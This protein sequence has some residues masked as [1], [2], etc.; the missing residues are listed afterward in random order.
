[1]RPVWLTLYNVF[2][3]PAL[4][5]IFRIYAVFSNKAKQGLEGRRDLFK[6]LNKSLPFFNNGKRTVIIH[7]SSLG[8][9]QQAMP[10]IDEL[11]KKDYN[12][13][14]SFFSPSGYNHSKLQH[15]DIIKIYLPLDTYPGMKKLLGIIKPDVIIFMRY[16]LWYNMLYI[17]KKKGMLTILANGR[18]DEKDWSWK[19]PVLSSM[20][21]DL[22]DMI[23]K[24]FVIDDEDYKNYS[25]IL[26][27]NVIK[28]GD[29]KFERVLQ[30]AQ[31]I[32]Q[33]I[34][35]DNLFSPRVIKDKKVFVIGSSWKEDEELTLPVIN[36][37]LEYEAGLLTFLVPHEPKEKKIA[38]I[39]RNIKDEYPNIKAIRFSGLNN[40]NGENFIIVDRVG[41]LMSL[42]SLAYASYVGGGFRSGLHNI[43]EPAVFNM[44]IFFSNLVKNSD[45][46]EKLIESGCGIVVKTRAQFYREFRKV[47]KE[48]NYRDEIGRK[49]KVVFESMSGTAKRIV[50]SL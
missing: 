20:K 29:S 11:V 22:Y 24:V 23:D 16:D 42:Y 15:K 28:V 40:Y 7:S 14:A 49:C 31:N 2:F 25:R 18:Y 9:Y 3:V 47:L 39:E 17:A 35:D 30:A 34:K 10:L 13:I 5:L 33:S 43:L 45:E 46:D 19:A 38:L 12:I 4:W 50:E 1:M 26:K 41:I 27:T 6:R 8:E 32:K 37:V 48:S 44:P 36:K 21:R